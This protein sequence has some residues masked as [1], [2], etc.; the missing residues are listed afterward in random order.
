MIT[1]HFSKN[2][3]IHKIRYHSCYSHL[4][5]CLIQILDLII[6]FYWFGNLLNALLDWSLIYF[7]YFLTQFLSLWLNVGFWRDFAF[8]SK[9]CGI[10]CWNFIFYFFFLR[11]LF[12]IN[13][14][15][16]CHYVSLVGSVSTNMF[17]VLQRIDNDN[18][19]FKRCRLMN[20][21]T[22]HII[23]KMQWKKGIETKI[24]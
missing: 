8:I 6:Y 24:K 20:V 17:Y 21:E 1:W 5:C 13:R 11:C 2:I 16:R 12:T 22:Q 14:V 4:L 10:F 15:Y 3:H 9:G 18:K 23:N 7:I 19:T